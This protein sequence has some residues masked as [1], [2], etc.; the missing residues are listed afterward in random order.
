MFFAKKDFLSSGS[1][2]P[3]LTALLKTLY[4]ITFRWNGLR[5]KIVNLETIV[6][7]IMGCWYVFL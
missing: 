7:S 4:L 1:P 2:K 6:Y 5:P 3:S